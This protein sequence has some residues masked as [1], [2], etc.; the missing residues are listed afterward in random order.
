MI[1]SRRLCRSWRL[2]EGA[3]HA[4]GM[5]NRASAFA[6]VKRAKTRSSTPPPADDATHAVAAAKGANAAKCKKEP[7][8]KEDLVRTAMLR[9]Q[10]GK[11]RTRGFTAACAGAG[12]KRNCRA[13]PCERGLPEVST[14]NFSAAVCTVANVLFA[15]SVAGG[16]RSW[17]PR[18]RLRYLRPFSGARAHILSSAD[19]R[20][21][22]RVFIFLA[23]VKSYGECATGD[24]STR[25][26]C[27]SSHTVSGWRHQTSLRP[28]T[29]SWDLSPFCKES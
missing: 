19:T 23:G 8:E 11:L 18:Q 15:Q 26:R 29:S 24:F 16:C 17:P 2:R 12:R 28:A 7:V 6:P 20:T 10:S 22:M 27:L 25:R 1:R 3:H 14:L 21:Q 13:E 4:S 5:E 9:M